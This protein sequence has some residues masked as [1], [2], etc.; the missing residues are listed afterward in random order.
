MRIEIY[1]DI[2]TWMFPKMGVPHGVP[3]VSILK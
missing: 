1:F 2:L 3:W